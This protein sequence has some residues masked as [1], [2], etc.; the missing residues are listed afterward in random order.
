[1]TCLKLWALVSWKCVKNQVP[2]SDTPHEVRQNS[3]AVRV[4]DTSQTAEYECA[5]HFSLRKAR[6]V[7]IFLQIFEN[8]V[9]GANRLNDFEVK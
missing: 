6:V 1:M 5:I 3:L 2:P 7:L 4:I 8:Y 9:S